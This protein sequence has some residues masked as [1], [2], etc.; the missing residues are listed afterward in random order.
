[1][2]KPTAALKP[3]VIFLLPKLS[4]GEVSFICL[5]SKHHLTFW[6]I[7]SKIFFPLLT[8]SAFLTWSVFTELLIMTHEM[9]LKRKIT[10]VNEYCLSQQTYYTETKRSC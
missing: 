1:M 3:E 9:F 4:A 2:V 8:I 5:C 10:S 7:S 6:L